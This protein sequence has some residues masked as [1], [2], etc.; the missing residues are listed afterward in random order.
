[1]ANFKISENGEDI[2]WFDLPLN[3]EIKL[4]QWGGDASGNKLELALEPV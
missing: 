1:M 2:S 3:R 4:L